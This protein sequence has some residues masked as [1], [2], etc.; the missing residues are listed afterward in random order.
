MSIQMTHF[1][2]FYGLQQSTNVS[3]EYNP[4]DCIH[5]NAHKCNKI[6]RRI[7]LWKSTNF[8]LVLRTG[9]FDHYVRESWILFST[10][11][12]YCTIQICA[13]RKHHVAHEIYETEKNIWS[14]L[15]FVDLRVCRLNWHMVGKAQKNKMKFLI[16]IILRIWKK[17]NSTTFP[18]KIAILIFRRAWNNA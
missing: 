2:T 12:T 15:I 4:C 11:Y 17:E 7:W 14:N 1:N 13:N 9:I 6:L 16:F 18:T 10:K 3:N 5:E 8:E